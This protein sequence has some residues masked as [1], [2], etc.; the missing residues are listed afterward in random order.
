MQIKIRQYQ[1]A[2]HDSILNLHIAGQKQTG[3]YIENPELDKDLDNIKSTY[4]DPG[5]DFLVVTI[6]KIVVGMGALKKL[7]KNTA[8]IKRMRVDQKYQGKKIGSKIL[9]TLIERAKK[10]GFKKIVLDTTNKQLV[11]QKLYESRG[12]KEFDRK[13]LEDM[14]MEVIFYELIL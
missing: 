1:D 10:L 4:I 5:G 2:D 8:E 3:S 7:D 13:N 11:A 12:F 14:N 6:N 9:D